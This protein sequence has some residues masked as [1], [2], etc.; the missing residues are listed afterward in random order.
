MHAEW[1][2]QL[3]TKVYGCYQQQLTMYEDNQTRLA[4]KE[5]QQTFLNDLMTIEL[6]DLKDA[7]LIERI[8]IFREHLKALNFNIEFFHAWNEVSANSYTE[9]TKIEHQEDKEIIACYKVITTQGLSDNHEIIDIVGALE[10]IE[11]TKYEVAKDS[12]IGSIKLQLLDMGIT[13]MKA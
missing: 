1:K 13:E 6:D 3:N 5:E 7:Y 4:T 8:D 11:P 10:P 9:Y 2:I 12:K